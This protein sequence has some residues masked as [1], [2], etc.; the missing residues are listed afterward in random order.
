MAVDTLPGSIAVVKPARAIQ[1]RR[2]QHA[3][4]SEEK[5]CAKMRLRTRSV[6][7]HF[8]SVAP[9]CR[10][11]QKVAE[12]ERGPTQTPRGSQIDHRD[13]QKYRLRVHRSRPVNRRLP[14]S[15]SL[16]VFLTGENSMMSRDRPEKVQFWRGTIDAWELHSLVGVEHR[17]N[18]TEPCRRMGR[19]GG[20]TASGTMNLRAVTPCH[21]AH[22][23]PSEQRW[24]G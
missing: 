19:V 3:V 1:A 14:S 24:Q 22:R 21:P 16:G 20:A 18:A 10:H 11:R 2:E 13:R 23:G 9:R 7:Q 4:L 8:L 6:T 12:S 5:A 17:S 15:G